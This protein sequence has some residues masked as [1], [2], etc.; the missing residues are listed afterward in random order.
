MVSR[1]SRRLPNSMAI[2]LTRMLS[3]AK[4]V[5]L[6]G[7]MVF[8]FVLLAGCGDGS[9][10]VPMGE[11]IGKVTIQG[12]PLVEGR[13]NYISHEG[14]SGASGDLNAD[15]TYLLEGPIPAGLYDV[16]ITFNIS[17]AQIGTDAEKVMKSVPI[18][19]LG[20]QTSGLTAN[21]M[22]GD[23]THDFDLK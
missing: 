9:E 19:Y 10:V 16:F 3:E 23:N 2:G 4:G 11:A 22:V 8:P 21:V 13:V 17:P 15:G 1:S 14:G 6:C 20:Q 5:L 18:Q 12:S 7:L